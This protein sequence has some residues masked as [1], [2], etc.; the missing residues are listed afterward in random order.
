MLSSGSHTWLI[1]QFL[2][3]F[4]V[5]ATTTC[6]CVLALLAPLVFA[7]L[8]VHISVCLDRR[9]ICHSHMSSS[10]AVMPL[11]LVPHSRGRWTHPCQ[12]SPP[13]PPPIAQS[14]HSHGKSC[15]AGLTCSRAFSTSVFEYRRLLYE[16]VCSKRAVNNSADV[17]SQQD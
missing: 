9:L 17:W 14:P 15:T 6:E 7:D 8:Y 10:E 1:V 4:A 3:L 12:H 2:L 16:Q 11:I 5:D 13:T